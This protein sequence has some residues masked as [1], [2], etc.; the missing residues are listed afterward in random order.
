[1][2]PRRSDATKRFTVPVTMHEVFPHGCHLMPESITEAQDYDEK[3]RPDAQ[4]WTN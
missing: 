3:T 4:R 1:M 2:S